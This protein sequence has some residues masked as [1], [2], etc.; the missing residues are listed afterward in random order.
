MKT[1]FHTH[2]NYCDGH[3]SAT[4]MAISAIELGFHQ[5]GF[6]S[7]APLPIPAQWSLSNNEQM[8]N[9]IADV[10]K[11]K[12]LFADKIE[13]FTGIEADYI[14]GMTTDFC[15]LRN[16]MG[17]EFIIG[18]VHLVR[19]PNTNEV[20]FIDG[21]K[22]FF[23][24]G[25]KEYFGG[26]G[27]KAAIA[28]FH[29]IKEMVNTQKFDILA[30]A[31]KIKMNNADRFFKE[32]DNWY[33]NEVSELVALIKEKNIILEVNTRGFYQKR[34]NDMYPSDFFLEKAI[35]LGIPIMINS[36][37]HKTHDLQQGFDEAFKILKRLGCKEITFR[38]NG[39]WS[40]TSLF[41]IISA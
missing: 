21:K 6:S 19:I 27:R 34:T 28:Y 12:S 37:A 23:D 1:N 17:F 10:E 35:G 33:R 4:E 25:L 11:C 39:N 14:P 7:H 30:H 3:A 29:Q 26:D 24:K 5:L 40:Q 22:S 41:D 38:K 9:Y 32:D 13:I 2:T 16:Q 18:A 20:W 8:Y 15:Q 31:D 36:D